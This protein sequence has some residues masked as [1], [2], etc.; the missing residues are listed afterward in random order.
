MSIT[1]AFR[2]L[3]LVLTAALFPATAFAGTTGNAPAKVTMKKITKQ[4]ANKAAMKATKGKG[5]AKGKHGAKAIKLV[6]R[7]H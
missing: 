7:T 2:V 3:A 1:K 6:R 4:S 5:K